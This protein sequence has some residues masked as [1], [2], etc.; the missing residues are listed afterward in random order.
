MTTLPAAV[1]PPPAGLAIWKMA[2][3][4]YRL[5]FANLPDFFRLAWVWIAFAYVVGRGLDKIALTSDAPSL[6]FVADIAIALFAVTFAGKWHRR[7]LLGTTAVGPTLKLAKRDVAFV[8]RAVPLLAAILF[9]LVVLI[10]LAIVAVLTSYYAMIGPMTVICIAGFLAAMYFFFRLS[11]ILPAA[12]T[13]AITF[14][15]RASWVATAGISLH[16]WGGSLLITLPLPIL[17]HLITTQAVFAVLR[18]DAI[19]LMP[20][21]NIAI[22]FVNTV[23][24]FLVVAMVAT[25][26]SLAYRALV[27]K[28]RA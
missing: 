5:V 3:A 14:G 20:T 13:D 7:A 8:A 28:A 15:W 27:P 9:P 18:F 11:L 24:F 23:V 19:S 10:W 4:A 16:L 21:L 17:T 12:A 6:H 2:T 1:V 25:Y 26:I 22:G